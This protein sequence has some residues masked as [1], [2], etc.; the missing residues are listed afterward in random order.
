MPT[1][2]ALYR[3]PVKGLSGESLTEVT[4]AAGE[5]FPGDRAFAIENGRSKFDPAAPRWVPKASFLMLMKNERLA[6]LTSRFEDATA[7]LT[8]CRAGSVVAE[9]RLDSEA[10]RRAIEAFF[11]AYA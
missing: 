9:G 6:G 8:I 4:L 2:A 3:Y 11:Q 5:T 1:I 10:G 7:T